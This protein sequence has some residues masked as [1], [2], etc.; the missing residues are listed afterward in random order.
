MPLSLPDVGGYFC[1]LLLPMAYPSPKAGKHKLIAAI[2]P[3]S[4]NIGMHN[5]YFMP[6]TG[7]MWKLMTDGAAH[8]GLISEQIDVEQES[9]DA[10]L[11]NGGMVICSMAP[12]DFTPAGHFI[13]LYGKDEEGYAVNDPFCVYRSNQKWTYEQ[14]EHQM[15][16]AWTLFN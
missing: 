4:V 12:G 16:A 13:V 5:D 11:Q 15:K 10:C 8:Y 9:I 14:L 2:R 6:G 3:S 7:T 1:V